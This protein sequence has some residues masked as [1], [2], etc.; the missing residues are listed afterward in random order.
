MAGL[1]DSG[2]YVQSQMLRYLNGLEFGS[3]EVRRNPLKRTN[4]RVMDGC[5]GSSSDSDP[6]ARSTTIEEVPASL[7][8]NRIEKVRVDFFQEC[9]I[10]SIRLTQQ[11]EVCRQ[12]T[13]LAKKDGLP[14]HA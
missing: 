1:Q 13:S 12:V 14:F 2:G 3:T 9:P 4:Q 11:V 7:T 10:V 6:R 8:K 5:I